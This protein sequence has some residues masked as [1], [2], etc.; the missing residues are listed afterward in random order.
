M[1]RTS[2]FS[3]S[4]DTSA[5][6]G[7][8]RRLEGLTPEAIGALAVEAINETVDS[9]YALGRKTMLRGINLTDDYIQ[10]KMTVE[11]ATPKAPKATITALG[12]RTHTTGLSHYGAMQMTKDV[13]WSNARI[14]AA[15]HKFGKWPGWTQRRGN[16][17]LGVSVDRKASGKSVEVVRGQRKKMG[18]I[19]SIP[20]KK[21]ND[22]NLVLFRRTASGSA[23]SLQGPSV[24][25]LF[26]V[27]IPMIYG[28][29]EEDLSKSVIEVAERELQK[30]LS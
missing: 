8:A 23:Q 22:G 26:R 19:F 25:Q 7:L 11:H 14:Q 21:D 3:V 20:G 15:G 10:R 9:A 17:A 13:N 1:A 16:A 12:G 24:Y 6:E 4:I 28:Q 27:A 18:P 30:V 5:V 29:V 2:S